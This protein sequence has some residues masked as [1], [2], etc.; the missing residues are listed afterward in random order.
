MLA[1]RQLQLKEVFFERD[2]ATV[3]HMIQKGMTSNVFLQPLL[4]E[5]LELLKLLD[6]HASVSHVFREANRLAHRG[7]S[8]SFECTMIDQSFAPLRILLADDYR[9]SCLPRF[10]P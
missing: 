10:V 1:A 9:G 2:S 4:H 7:H 6:W 3:V 5:V 8:S